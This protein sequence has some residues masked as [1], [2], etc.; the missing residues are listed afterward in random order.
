MFVT[1]FIFLDLELFSLFL[2]RMLLPFLG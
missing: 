1:I 2:T